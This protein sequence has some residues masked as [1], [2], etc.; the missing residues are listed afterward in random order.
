MGTMGVCCR[1]TSTAG[2]EYGT[3]YLRYMAVEHLY[4]SPDEGNLEE[5]FC[6]TKEEELGAT[7]EA[8]RCI[9]KPL[10]H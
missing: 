8:Y 7:G 5:R 9:Q 1:K 3:A 10:S 4:Q 2:I 6:K